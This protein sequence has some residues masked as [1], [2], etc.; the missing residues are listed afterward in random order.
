MTCEQFRPGNVRMASYVCF[1]FAVATLQDKKRMDRKMMSFQLLHLLYLCVNCLWQRSETPRHLI[2]NQSHPY[3]CWVSFFSNFFFEMYA[4]SG[5]RHLNQHF[6]DTDEE[7]YEDRNDPEYKPTGKRTTQVSN[8]KRS[9]RKKRKKK[10]RKRPPKVLKKRVCRKN[11]DNESVEESDDDENDKNE[12]SDDDEDDKNE[13]SDDDENDKNEESDDDENDAKKH[14]ESDIRTWRVAG[15]QPI[16]DQYFKSHNAFSNLVGLASEKKREKE[17]RDGKETCALNNGTQF[18]SITKKD[19]RSL[20]KMMSCGS[21]V[22]VIDT[23]NG[24]TKQILD[25]DDGFF[26]STTRGPRTWVVVNS[27]EDEC[28]RL[29]SL[30]HFIKH[31]EYIVENEKLIDYFARNVCLLPASRLTNR[32]ILNCL[33]EKDMDTSDCVER[34]DYESMFESVRPNS[35][36]K[37]FDVIWLDLMCTTSTLDVKLLKEAHRFTRDRG[38]VL[39]TLSLRGGGGVEYAKELCADLFEAGTMKFMTYAGGSSSSSSRQAC[40]SPMFFCYGVTK[41]YAV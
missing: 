13:E 9:K 5:F 7:Y 39:I 19:Q 3:L 36:F 14:K 2:R 17:M 25:H 6:S 34:L 41:P 37:P 4:D 23:F 8:S 10:P 24:C 15:K 40:G 32:D 16:N 29:R 28:E 11:V 18:H 21:K 1:V 26:D 33:R 38:Y 31:T 27:N 20:V 22:L 35:N 12:E 30:S